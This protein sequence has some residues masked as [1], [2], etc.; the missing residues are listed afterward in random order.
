M[1]YKQFKDISVSTL[2]LGALHFLMDSTN[3]PHIERRDAKRV[4]DASFAGG[5][6]YIDTAYTYQNGDS[7]IFLGEAL[8]DRPRDSYYLGTKYYAKPGMEI[9]EVFEEQCRRLNTDYFDFYMFHSLDANY[10]NAYTDPKRD[11]LGYL[12][13][14]KELGRIRYIGFSSHADPATLSRF[15]EW[16]DSFDMALIQINY[17]DWT[18]LDARGQYELLKEHQKP[19]WVMEPLKAGRLCTLNDAAAG[20]LKSFAPNRSLA[21]WGFRFLM[22][23]DN[24]QTVLSGM[25]TVEMVEENC[26]IFDKYDPLSDAEQEVLGRAIDAFINDL[27][28]PCSACRYCCDT[29]P[30]ELNIPLLIRAYNELT[31]SGHTWKLA[32][33]DG[34]AG[35]E[36]CQQCE[37]CLD[38]CPQKI[39]I[40]AVL[41]KFAELRAKK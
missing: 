11:M 41:E 16:N 2:G 4:L 14:Q 35:P 30:A 10:I 23:L 36:E 12:L 22:G 25:N 24:V 32:E 19:T 28:V 39:N 3:P 27:G 21:S 9:E 40:P 17:L 33:L 26:E 29:C 7:E 38:Y 20:I 6:N 15:L 18:N 5:I 8:A 1:R 37:T 34:A 13:K 31:I